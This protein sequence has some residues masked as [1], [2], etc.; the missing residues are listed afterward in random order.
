MKVCLL[1]QCI[2]CHRFKL[3]NGEWDHTDMYEKIMESVD[4]GIVSLS[5]D[6]C[7]DCREDLQGRRVMLDG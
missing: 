3:V 4:D 1:T 7:F 5:P 6:V 2:F